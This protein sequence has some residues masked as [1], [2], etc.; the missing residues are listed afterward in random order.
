[1]DRTELLNEIQSYLGKFKQLDIN[2]FQHELDEMNILNTCFLN[3]KVNEKQFHNGYGVRSVWMG[4]GAEDIQ[5][6]VQPDGWMGEEQ[7]LYAKE[8]SLKQLL[9]VK[10]FVKTLHDARIAEIRRTQDNPKMD[11]L[12][13]KIEE[14]AN[15]C[16]AAAGKDYEARIT[17][18]RRQC[19]GP[20]DYHALVITEEKD[21]IGSI[22]LRQDKFGKLTYNVQTPLGGSYADDFELVPEKM[23]EQLKEAIEEI[24]GGKINLNPKGTIS[25]V[26]TF[27]DIYGKGYIACNIDDVRQCSKRMKE[28]EYDECERLEKYGRADGYE[29]YKQY[30]AS[31]AEKYYANEVKLAQREDANRGRRR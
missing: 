20:H 16:M 23:E 17:V 2:T 11:S 7:Q 8:M 18:G 13:P 28:A 6:I 22:P 24:V 19:D 27:T 29:Q 30:K 12:F 9:G 3:R 21:Y 15:R 10:E 31:L 4:R 14:F 25:D 5:V 26:F 1:M